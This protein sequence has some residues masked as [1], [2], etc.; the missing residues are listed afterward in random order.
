VGRGRYPLPVDR[1]KHGAATACGPGVT[2]PLQMTYDMA[3]SAEHASEVGTTRLSTWWP[4]G[5]SASGQAG[6]L[7]MLEP[8]VGGRTF[9]RTPDRTEFDWGRSPCGARRG[10]L[11][12]Y[13]ISAVTGAKPPRP[14]ER[15]NGYSRGS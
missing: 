4:A 8:R 15:G 13:G 5:H 9:E 7:V 3:C 11:D 2:G 12:T 14:E 6:T 1:G 10:A